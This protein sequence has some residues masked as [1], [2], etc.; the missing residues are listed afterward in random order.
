MLSVLG[1]S[2]GSVTTAS[3]QGQT[4]DIKVL[5]RGEDWQCASMEEREVARNEL[6]QI[7]DMAITTFASASTA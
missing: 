3:G 7:V 5:E 6:H 2:S 4:T 1:L